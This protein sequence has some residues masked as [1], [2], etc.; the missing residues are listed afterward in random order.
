MTT[1]FSQVYDMDL[2]ITVFAA[3]NHLPIIEQ[4][5]EFAAINLKK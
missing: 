1:H 2:V 4:V 5:L 3:L